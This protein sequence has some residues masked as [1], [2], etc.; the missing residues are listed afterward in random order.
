MNIKDYHVLLLVSTGM[1]DST[2]LEEPKLK[3]LIE[4]LKV[5]LKENCEDILLISDY[6]KVMNRVNRKYADL[7]WQM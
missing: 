3:A 4:G 2:T 6:L 5:V 1:N 7:D